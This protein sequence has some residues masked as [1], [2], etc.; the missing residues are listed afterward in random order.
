M[1]HFALIFAVVA[2]LLICVTTVWAADTPQTLTIDQPTLIAAVPA[3]DASIEVSTIPKPKSSGLSFGP[4]G[5]SVTY[6]NDGDNYGLAAGTELGRKDR[7]VAQG[8][9]VFEPVNKNQV[10]LGATIGYDIPIGDVLTLTPLVG[11]LQPVTEGLDGTLNG[12][13][14]YGGSASFKF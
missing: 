1:K 6:L 7:V 10:G 9:I 5:I 8:W 11:V 3:E 2:L 4:N 14:V 12:K 13:F